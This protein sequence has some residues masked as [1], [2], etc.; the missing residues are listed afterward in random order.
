MVSRFFC[1]T[2]TLFLLVRISN[3]NYSAG[4]NFK[5]LECEDVFE[6]NDTQIVWFISSPYR[7]S[8]EI[9]EI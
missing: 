9:P 8:G 3:D 2:L 4:E 5:T 7:G 1:F 6:D